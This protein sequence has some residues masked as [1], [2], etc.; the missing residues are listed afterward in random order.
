[1]PAATTHFQNQSVQFFL[2]GF[3]PPNTILN[4]LVINL[5]LFAPFLAQEPAMR[6]IPHALA[7]LLAALA[8]ASLLAACGKPP[9]GP[10][11]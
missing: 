8:A 3:L 6:S 5:S 4:R 11:P 2:T 7:P 9:G 1:M 10:P